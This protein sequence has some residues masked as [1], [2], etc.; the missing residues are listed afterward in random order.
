MHAFEQ[1]TWDRPE[2]EEEEEEGPHID[3]K[4][5]QEEEKENETISQPQESVDDRGKD[6]I[7]APTPVEDEDLPAGW[8]SIVDPD[9]GDVYYSNEVTG[10]TTW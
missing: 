4:S 2:F 6:V 3:M 9:S 8:F 10:E 5:S 7:P 1:T